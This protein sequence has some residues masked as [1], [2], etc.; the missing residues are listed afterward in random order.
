MLDVW[1]SREAEDPQTIID[2]HY[3]DIFVVRE[4]FSVV[5]RAVGPRDGVAAAVEKC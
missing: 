5:E 1:S 4:V 2:S 3:Y